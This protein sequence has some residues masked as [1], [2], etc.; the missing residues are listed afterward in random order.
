MTAVLHADARRPI[1]PEERDMT[2]EQDAAEAA[3]QTA[4]KR[5]GL[6]LP[7]GRRRSADS[8]EQA[9][10]SVQ[11][12]ESVGT[13]TAQAT[14][15][16]TDDEE[17]AEEPKL[18][19]WKRRKLRIQLAGTF[20]AYP[21]LLAL[22]PKEKFVFRSDYFEIDNSVACVLAYVHADGAQDPYPPFWGIH[23]IPEGLASGVTAVVLE[24]VVR[25]TDKWI[26]QESKASERLVGLEANEANSEGSSSNAVRKAG[27][28][29]T[30]I[31]ITLEELQNGAAYLSVHNRLLL[32]AKDLPT[33]E[34]AIVSV[35]SQYIEWFNTLSVAPYHGEQRDELSTLFER[36]EKKR[37][38]GFGFTSTE[39]AGSFS[40][41]TNG[42]ADRT[43]ELVGYM[44]G[45]VNDSAVLFD[46]NG[47]RRHVVI[48]NSAVSEWM[49]RQFYSNMWC[50]KISQSALLSN[51]S[52]VHLVLDNTDLDQLGPRLEGLTSW[53]DMSTG[54]VNMFE[55]F[56]DQ[57][58]EL[59]IF[60]AQMLKLEL[61]YQQLHTASGAEMATITNHL[62]RK[63]LRQFYIDQ[64]MFAENAQHRRDQLR[65]VGIPHDQVPILQLFG[66]YLDTEYKNILNAKSQ[67]PDEMRAVNVL[68]KV[69]DDLLETNGDLFNNHT[70]GS[71]DG[72][73]EAKRVVYK[74]SSLERRGANVA[75][76]QLINITDFAIAKLRA[77]DVV[78]VH[79]AERIVPQVK[80]FMAE[81][82]SRLM[83]RGGRV[84]YSYNSIE[85]M[86]DD[87]DFN[88]FDA[89]DYTI[90]GQMRENTVLQYQALLGQQLPVGLA[91]LIV[92]QDDQLQYLRRGVTNAVFH[93]DLALGVNPAREAQ[94]REVH[95]QARNA[96]R[97]K[98]QEEIKSENAVTG[99]R[100]IA[101][102][103]P[104]TK[105]AAGAKTAAIS[106]QLS[107]GQPATRRERTARREGRTS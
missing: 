17:D 14:D 32:K 3:S 61:M 57:E 52:V 89:A 16:S 34:A 22:K 54:D 24:Q 49:G 5:P 77:G 51:H 105:A 46:A 7:W 39:Y 12:A 20:D 72:V 106:G 10:E 65:L 25:R 83:A 62:L 80:E 68:R 1:S 104:G 33:L 86:L 58:D 81:Q 71:I 8:D 84:V 53:I 70:A 94:R 79:G 99:A 26:E 103:R 107:S 13:G 45:D 35:S 21:H 29:A 15:T 92:A 67:D 87:K 59:A 101:A 30:D 85:K 56:G 6:R 48:A 64:G 19:W 73:R 102:P 88:V 95:R 28:A 40:L 9:V 47:F 44:V 60:A 50:S 31:D 11:S 4:G 38:A 91:G 98:Q 41:V 63:I 96:K 97:R 27:K 76:A 43:G 69:T 2:M 18:S 78:I 93:L 37:G 36:N 90:L 74:F 100:R 66:S 23:R 82:F 75:M 55:M 42:V